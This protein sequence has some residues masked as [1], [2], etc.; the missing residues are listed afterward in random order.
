MNYRSGL[1]RQLVASGNFSVSKKSSVLLE[2]CLGTCVG[3][4]IWDREAGVGGLL[5]LLLPEWSGTGQPWREAA[6]ANTGLPVFIRA[7]CAAG[8][9]VDHLEASVAGGA[10]VG[11]VSKR[12]LDLNVGGRT[13]EVVNKFLK[14]RK[15]P[16][17]HEETGG[18]FS[19]KLG[20]NLETLATSV[21]PINQEH[22]A[23]ATDFQKP[24]PDEIAQMIDRV[25]PIPQV[26]LKLARMMRSDD[27]DLTEIAREIKQDQVI[28]A[29]VIRLSNSSYLGLKKRIDTIDRALVILGEKMLF[30]MV[31][32]A[33]MEFYFADTSQGY[34]LCKGGLFRHAL[35]TAMIA[36]ALATFTGRVEP[37]IAYTAGLL[38]DIGK[39]VLDKYVYSIY[40]YFYRRTQEEAVDLYQ[41]EKE[42]I[43]FTHPEAGGLLAENWLL[44]DNLVDTIRHH[45]YPEQSTVEP[46][47][48]HLIY[49]ADFLMSRFRVGQELDCI[50]MDRFSARLDRLGLAPAHFQSVVEL[51]PQSIFDSALE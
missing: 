22:S 2:A 9:T 14:R 46:A 51:I 39:V 26:A 28:S 17:R 19:C 40:P 1:R 49:L 32:S 7:L 45:H 4:A 27:Y 33:A 3:V 25:R 12:D 24:T 6:Y 37:Q 38:H 42:E 15:I 13:V 31:I 47:L 35:G 36:E 5:H 41:A 43:G 30:Q 8:A 50:N 29:N 34:S 18:Y 10:L 48:T 21:E 23:P 11:P 44:P 20:L 16:V